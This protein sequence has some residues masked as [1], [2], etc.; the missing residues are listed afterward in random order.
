MKLKLKTK[1]PTKKYYFYSFINLNLTLYLIITVFH[2]LSSKEFQ[3]NLIV[4]DSKINLLI[5]GS[6]NISL[7][8]EYFYLE[9]NQVLI[10]GIPK[11]NSCKNNY[12]IEGPE[13]TVTLIFKDQMEYCSQ[14]FEKCENIKEID[15]SEFDFS[16]IKNMSHMFRD[17]INLEKIGFG[18]INTSLV[19]NMESLFFGCSK[20][21]SVD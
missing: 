9:P 14:M 18:K 8:S 6:G 20:L 16:E 4:Y 3:N 13:A 5:Q 15:L 2:Y 11:N 21:I 19:E 10:N 12:Y 7:F 17:C 1:T